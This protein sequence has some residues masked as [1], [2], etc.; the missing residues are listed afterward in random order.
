MF[1]IV[2]FYFIVYFFEGYIWCRDVFCENNVICFD[3]ISGYICYCYR[4]YIDVN[5]FIGWY[6]SKCYR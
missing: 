1:F 5:C 3:V 2:D 4:G 6:L